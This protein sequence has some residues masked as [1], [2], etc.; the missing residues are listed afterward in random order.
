V[1]QLED[2]LIN[3]KDLGYSNILLIAPSLNIVPNIIIYSIAKQADILAIPLK[4]KVI[5]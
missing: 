4:S 2:R 5:E 3:T 1:I